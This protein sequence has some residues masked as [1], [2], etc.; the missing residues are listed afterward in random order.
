MNP[1]NFT[2]QIERSQQRLARIEQ[3][4][5]TRSSDDERLEEAIAEVSAT[6]EEMQVATEEWL[7]IR[8]ELEQ[9]RKRYQELFE[10]APDGYLVTDAQGTI[11]E[12]NRAA[13]T[14]LNVPKRFLFG[15]P[16]FV[17]IAKSDRYR[18]HLQEH[19]LDSLQQRS[20]LEVSG[21]PPFNG[22]ACAD[23]RFPVNLQPRSGQPFPVVLSVST[24][25]N[26]QGDILGWRWLIRDLREQ[27]QA[28][29]VRRELEVQQ[30]LNQ[31]K[32]NL[33]HSISHEFRTPLNMILMS[34]GM[35]ERYLYSKQDGQKQRISERIIES[36]QILLRLLEKIE[37]IYK[38]NSQ[39]PSLVA[40]ELES[41]C[42]EM[43]AEQ[44][45]FAPQHKIHFH[46]ACQRQSVCLDVE[47][48][49]QILSNLL[50]NALK[51]SHNDKPVLL[52]VCDEADTI[53]FLIQDWGIGIPEADQSRLFELFYRGGNINEISGTGLGLAIVKKATDLLGG[54]ISFISKVGVGS[55]FTVTLP[56]H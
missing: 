48:L 29:A 38:D 9:E 16:L 36:V 47:L 5:N 37:F 21:T 34:A 13:A 30:K 26:P 27:K 17:F 49:R 18:F 25:Y 51:Y 44:T 43:I 39:L 41:F 55:T 10:E 20:N 15:K 45:R 32:T 31:F 7:A 28:E 56:L 50:A 14:L 24:S 23:R 40:V 8:Q 3:P 53:N 33:L 12:A 52:A 22:G 54:E 11:V 2:Q 4:T 6:L 35:I 46:Y 19:W 1:E 42:R